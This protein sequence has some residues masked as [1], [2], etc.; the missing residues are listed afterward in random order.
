M[1]V[2]RKSISVLILILTSSSVKSLANVTKEISLAFY[3]CRVKHKFQ[4]RMSVR[5]LKAY[6]KIF[7]WNQ[8]TFK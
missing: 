7:V 3:T 1:T 6:F 4:S 5:S 8:N 2:S